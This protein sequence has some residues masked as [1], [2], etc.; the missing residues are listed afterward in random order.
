MAAGMNSSGGGFDVA[1][2]HDDVAKKA[3]S[4]IRADTMLCETPDKKPVSDFE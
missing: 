3:E 4:R 1:A 2:D